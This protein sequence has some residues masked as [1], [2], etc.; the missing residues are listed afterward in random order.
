MSGCQNLTAEQEITRVRRAIPFASSRG[1]AIVDAAEALSIAEY[2]LN[3]LKK[4]DPD[5][6]C[7]GS[8]YSHKPHGNCTGYSTDRT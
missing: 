2:L 1:R 7:T 5:E 8:G 3:R 4:I 6:Q